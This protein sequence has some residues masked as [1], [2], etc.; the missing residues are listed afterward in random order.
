MKKNKINLLSAI[1]FL[2]F[3]TS[4]HALSFELGKI[5][6][7]SQLQ[8][9]LRAEIQ[10]VI[11]KKE[12]ITDLTFNLSSD[13]LYRS[14]GIEKNAAIDSTDLKLVKNQKGEDVLILS[15]SKEVTDSF[16]DLLITVNDGRKK[17]TREINFY[18]N[19][20]S[21]GIKKIAKN[22]SSKN[23]MNTAV[24]KSS[25]DTVYK[26]ARENQ[27]QGVSRA[28]M[29][30]A[31]FNLNPNAFEKNDINQLKIGSTITLPQEDYFKN[32]SS[33]AAV[34]ELKNLS[35]KIPTTKDTPD[36][37]KVSRFTPL[38]KI[39]DKSIDKISTPQ[40]SNKKNDALDKMIAFE[41][42]IN[43]L[44]EK[45]NE[46]YRLNEEIRINEENKKNAELNQTQVYENAP[47]HRLINSVLSSFH[48]NGNSNPVI[49]FSASVLFFLFLI[50]LLLFI[51]IVQFRKMDAWKK[52][53]NRSYEETLKKK[54]K[55]SHHMPINKKP[56]EAEKQKPKNWRFY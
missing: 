54:T 39:I 17:I 42:K 8:E 37:E 21:D 53:I 48:F 20:E 26:I 27:M 18:V 13:E 10:L 44:E 5:T 14:F 1:F 43:A 28:Q 9:P 30:A 31:I 45:L 52:N 49:I 16:F 25:E 11:D 41:E 38:K 29:I 33:E 36:T 32:L 55:F 56:S 6:V 19:Q 40:N 51:R 35:E 22:S 12:S 50:V 24:I 2:A 34:N 3:F 23:N 7:Y 47:M 46:A 15:S 4:H